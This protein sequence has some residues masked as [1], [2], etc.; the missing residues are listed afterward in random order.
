MARTS[1]LEPLFDS[2]DHVLS[3]NHAQ[4]TVAGLGRM[5]EQGWGSGRG[6]RRRKFAADVPGFAHPRHHQASW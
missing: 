1:S 4:V 2:E 6:K 5:H 3:R